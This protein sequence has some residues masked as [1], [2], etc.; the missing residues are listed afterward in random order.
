[1]TRRRRA[2]DLDRE[3]HAHL[4]LEAEEQSEAG[5]PPA[6][7]RIETGRWAQASVK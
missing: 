3:I 6:E 7:A 5:G 4:E 2:R 1:M